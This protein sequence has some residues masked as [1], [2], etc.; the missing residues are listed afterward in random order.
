MTMKTK[1]RSL[2]LVGLELAPGAAAC[3]VARFVELAALE[4]N[5][6]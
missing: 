6:Q 2:E 1:F 4:R 5:Q 3:L